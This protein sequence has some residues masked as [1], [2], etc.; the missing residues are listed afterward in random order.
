MSVSVHV[1]GFGFGFGLGLVRVKVAKIT[2][3]EWVCI[4]IDDLWGMC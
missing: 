1:H 3:T 4:L 2:N